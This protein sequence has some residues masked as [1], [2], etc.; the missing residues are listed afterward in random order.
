MFGVVWD[1]EGNHSVAHEFQG[2]L[3]I[4][5]RC[6]LD[7]TIDVNVDQ[8]ELDEGNGNMVNLEEAKQQIAEL[9]TEL[10][11]LSM[12]YHQLREV[13]TSVNRI[14]GWLE[15]AAGTKDVAKFYS[16][17]QKAI[18]AGRMLQ[19][20]VIQI[21]TVSGP[22]GWLMLGTSAVATAMTAGSIMQEIDNH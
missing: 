5:C 21:Q 18:A 22:I 16:L 7:I 20:L 6:D 3:S 14:L 12:N 8:M 4:H 17:M 11:G 9:K 10:N 2:G 13:E 15:E 19:M 1:L